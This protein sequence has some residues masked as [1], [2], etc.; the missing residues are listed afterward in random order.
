MTSDFT[1]TQPGLKK[2]PVKPSGPEIGKILFRPVSP[3]RDRVKPYAPPTPSLR[4]FPFPSPPPGR[5]R[6]KPSRRRRRWG[7]SSSSSGLL[8]RGSDISVGTPHF[9]KGRGGGAACGRIGSMVGRRF[10]GGC[11]AAVRFF[12]SLCVPLF[13]PRLAYMV[14]VG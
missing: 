6:A 7:S 4:F 9:G 12:F 2:A 1:V 11:V 3:T 14:S 13:L 8:R 5:W 10:C